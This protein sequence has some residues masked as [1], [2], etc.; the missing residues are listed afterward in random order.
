MSDVSTMREVMTSDL[1]VLFL[2]RANIA[3]AIAILVVLAARPMVRRLIGPTQGYWLWALVPV[4]AATSLF[5][6]L[7]DF[8]S[9]WRQ[10]GTG[11]NDFSIPY[12]GPLLVAFFIGAA[13]TLVLFVIGEVRFRRMAR[14]GLAGP[15]VMGLAWQTIVVP[16]DYHERFG[17]AERA[18]ISR[19][20]LT[21]IDRSHPLHNRLIAAALL[22]GWFNPLV[23]V[24][25]HCM[26]LDQEL[27]CDAAV[28][29]QNPGSRRAYAETLLKAHSD[30]PW[31][32]FACALA[33]GGRHPLEVRL[34]ALR[35]PKVSLRRYLVAAGLVS[36]LAAATALGIWTLAPQTFGA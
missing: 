10:M 35:S 8:M 34:Q 7:Q 23:H 5:P 15:A 26:R 12:S 6:S 21:H 30:T 14:A 20:E 16:H 36:G 9:S 25:A 32:T 27:A 19:H 24:A 4:A 11:G 1:A 28:M 33:D 29:E 18:L 3:A 2:L 22:L 13:V 31:S 17:P